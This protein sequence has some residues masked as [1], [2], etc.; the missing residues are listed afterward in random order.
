MPKITFVILLVMILVSC[1]H[2]K[3]DNSHQRYII[4]S[5][6]VAEIICLL[7]GGK[8]IVAI[9]KECD[10]PTYLKRKEVIGNF[11]KIDFEKILNLNPT[12]VFTAGLEQENLATELKK[13]NI[14]TEKIH[15][16]SI[17]EMLDAILR[18]GFLIGKQE[19]ARCVVDSLKTEIKAIP[20]RNKNPRVYIEIYGNPIMS[21]SSDSFV[22]Q[23]V[24]LS[25]GKNIFSTLPRDYSRIDPEAVIAANPEIIILT[26][27]GIKAEEVK[28]RKGWEVISA[29]KYN[30]IYD[31]DDINPDLILR[32]SP[33]CIIGIKEMQSIFYED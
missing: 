7:E 21:A 3:N 9:S 18:L 22:G 32:A 4:T 5:P 24:N 1:S 15:V 31:L 28:N 20:V 6:E 8:N 25:G 30:R 10:Y 26:Y 14:P 29:V 16:H 23:L 13:L 12:L 33:R 19:R 11:G 17:N 27:P 2:S